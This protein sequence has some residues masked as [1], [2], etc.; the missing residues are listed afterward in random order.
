M[1]DTL[2]ARSY[3]RTPGIPPP[4]LDAFRLRQHP[5]SIRGFEAVQS[6]VDPNDT[7]CEYFFG[8]SLVLGDTGGCRVYWVPAKEWM[9]GA[10]VRPVLASEL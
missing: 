8:V 6:R 4:F 7:R 5:C 3:T 10:P 1:Q 9:T 2:R